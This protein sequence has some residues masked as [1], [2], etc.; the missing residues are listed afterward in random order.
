[1]DNPKN[2]SNTANVMRHFSVPATALLVLALAP[3]GLWAQR[4]FVLG[5]VPT[6]GSALESPLPAPVVN[7][8]YLRNQLRHPR[9]VDAWV[10]KR[11]ALM[12]MFEARGV[13]YPAAELYMRVFKR[14]RVIELWARS[15]NKD[16]F[17]L[18]K[19]YEICALSGIGPKRKQGDG[20]TP[21]GF[22]YVDFLNP[23]S[24][25]HLSLHLNYPNT[26]DRLLGR[27]DALG[28]EIFIHGGCLT[29]GCLAV[30]DESIKE[31]YWLAVEAGGVGQQRIPVHIFPARLEAPMVAMLNDSFDGD[32]A[33]VDFWSSLRGG[34]DYF[35][36]HRTLP[37]I[38]VS[39]RGRYLMPGEVDPL[40]TELGPAILGEPANTL[41]LD[42]AA[43]ASDGLLG[44]PV[45]APAPTKPAGPQLLGAPVKPPTA[46]TTGIRR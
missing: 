9:V 40:E 20:Q 6:L 22:Y 18:I 43:K 8:D 46:D 41:P 39:T 35:E 28:G 33:L 36:R 16:T 23:Q 29:E 32:D 42:E 34:Y 44:K 19:E 38:R 37:E 11:F 2:F 4:A 7:P 10:S 13:A 12:E 17:T 27:R 3:S 31:L 14:E 24:E 25:F 21:E 15:A 45:A 26:A 1:M 30:T 5:A